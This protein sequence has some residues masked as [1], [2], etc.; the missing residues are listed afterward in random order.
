VSGCGEGADELDACGWTEGE[1]DA[2]LDD[3]AKALADPTA[4]VWRGFDEKA[5]L[6][7]LDGAEWLEP[8]AVGGL[9]DDEGKLGLH[10]RP[11]VLELA[12]HGSVDSLLSEGQC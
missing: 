5:I 2:R 3:S 7:E 11:Y 8:D 1:L 12:V 4:G 9:V 10:P 6:R